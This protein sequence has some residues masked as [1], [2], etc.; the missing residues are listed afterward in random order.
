MSHADPCL[1]VKGTMETKDYIAVAWY[2][3]DATIISSDQNLADEFIR[4]LKDRFKVTTEP[5]TEMLGIRINRYKNG[6]TFISQEKYI[7]QMLEKHGYSGEHGNRS[8][9]NIPLPTSM[10]APDHLKETN[11][12][13]DG[14]TNFQKKM[15]S[16]IYA[17]GSRLDCCYAISYLCR[18]MHAPTTLHLHWVS[19]L[20]KYLRKHQDLGIEYKANGDHQLKGYCDASYVDDKVGESQQLGSWLHITTRLFLSIFR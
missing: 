20:F 2:V 14:I 6:N 16:L 18:H 15:G 12:D 11:L 4:K 10:I 13:E 5:L 8:T 9:H 17:L 1:W 7:N 19:H 3:D